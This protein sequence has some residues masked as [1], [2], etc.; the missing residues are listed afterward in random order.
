MRTAVS[1]REHLN[2]SVARRRFNYFLRVSCAGAE[3]A[4]SLCLQ[5]DSVA[6]PKHKPAYLPL[7]LTALFPR[8]LRTFQ[9]FGTCERLVLGSYAFFRASSSHSLHLSTSCRACSYSFFKSSK[10]D[11]E[12]PG[13]SQAFVN[14]G[15]FAGSVS[16]DCRG[17]L[18]IQNRSIS[19]RF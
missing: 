13:L 18:K 10:S 6:A 11:I 5:L 1:S 12:R 7:Q 14:M 17:G 19:V 8:S 9:F 3:E 15:S 4:A 16:V 2:F